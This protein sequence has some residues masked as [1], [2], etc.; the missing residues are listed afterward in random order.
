MKGDTNF[1]AAL[2][3]ST[4]SSGTFRVTRTF[5]FAEEAILRTWLALEK[6]LQMNPRDSISEMSIRQCQESEEWPT[7]VTICKVCWSIDPPLNWKET[8]HTRWLYTCFQSGVKAI[9]SG[10]W[11]TICVAMPSLALYKSR[12]RMAEAVKEK[13]RLWSACF[14]QIPRKVFA[15]CELCTRWHGVTW[16]C[17]FCQNCIPQEVWG[18]VITCNTRV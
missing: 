17:V 9:P 13:D 10:W 11:G 2:S 15:F 12:W 3:I 18:L 1:G 14:P 16:V 7:V 6:F 5:C 8:A 4:A